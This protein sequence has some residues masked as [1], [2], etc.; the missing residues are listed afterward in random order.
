MADILAEAQKL[1]TAA[2]DASREQREQISQDLLFTDPSNP[3][4]WEDATRIAR[5]NDPGGRR[6]C[7]VMDQTGQYVANIAG[8]IEQQPPSIHAIPVSGGAD[9]DAAEQIDGRFRHIEHMSRASQHYARALTSA[10]RVGVGYLVVRPEI[11]NPSLNWQEPRIGS[12]PDPLR[13]VYDPWSVDTDGKDSTFGF[14]LSSWNTKVFLKR[15]PKKDISDFG[16]T[17]NPRTR[18][19]RKSVLIVEQWFMD[20]AIRTKFVYTDAAGAQQADTPEDY[21]KAC[22]AAG[23]RLPVDREYSEKYQ[24]VKWRRMSGADVLEESI[25]PADGIGIVPVYGYMGF[26]NGRMTYCG[27]GRR[28][29]LPQ[30]AYN[31]HASES[32][33]YM[34]TAPKV[35]YWV[36]K[37]AAAGYEKLLDRMSVETRA[38]MPFNDMDDEGAIATPTRVNPAANIVNHEQGMLRAKADIQAALGMYP[39][40]LGQESNAHSGIAIEKRKQQGEASTGH[41]QSHMA[42]SLG[43]VGNLVMQMDKTLTDTR[44][45][46]PI[47]GVD[48]SSGSITVDPAQQ[49]AFQRNRSGVTINPAVGDYGVR[50]VVGASYSTQ[51]SQ[52]NDAFGEIMRGNPELAPMVAPFWAQTLDFPG[53]DKFAQAMAAM[54]PEPVRAILQPEGGDDAPDPAKLTQQLAQMKQALAEALKHAHEAQDD[55]DQAVAQKAQADRDAKVKEREN[56]IAMYEAE[57]ERLKVTGA[58][59]EQIQAIVADLINDMLS[60]PG[61]L[62]GDPAPVPSP[63]SSADLPTDPV[64]QSPAVPGELTPAVPDQQQPPQ[65]ENVNV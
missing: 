22:E 40:N 35:P 14:L 10:A 1:Y 4:Q 25:Y 34:A 36:S 44:R 59:D 50:V 19:E 49:V 62:P 55:A 30:Q 33:A 27:V 52:T 15:W 13:V 3:Q 53:S 24:C 37:R 28:A 43:Q 42:A 54:A 61:P 58:N 5:E 9:K 47:M 46:Q 65:P 63:P 7:L 2:L 31:Y 60:Q 56:D 45:K 64:S 38:W 23:Q 41:F 20:A 48:G 39:D 57:T 6:P 32:L 21:F 51:R 8:Q 18:D 16:S 26:A 29:R 12:E 17:E 11:V